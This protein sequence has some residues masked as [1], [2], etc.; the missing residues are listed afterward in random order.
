MKHM[1]ISVRDSLEIWIICILFMANIFIIGAQDGNKKVVLITGS[2]GGIGKATAELLIEEG[3][4]VYGGDILLEKNQY[5]TEIGGY[6]LKMDISR[7]DEVEAGVEQIIKEQGRIDVLF[8]NAGYS[9]HGPVECVD[10]MDA[11][12]QFD[13]NVFGHARCVKAVL[14]YMR[15]HGGGNIIINTSLGGKI[16]APGMSWYTA[17][18]YALEAFADGL[19]MEVRKF[20][21][22]VSVIEP[23]AVLTDIHKNALPTLEKVKQSPEAGNYDIDTYEKNFIKRSSRGI[24]PSG[25]ANS[26]LRI[27]KSEYPERRYMPTLDARLAYN[28]HSLFG[29]GMTD[30]LLL[31][32]F[33]GTHQPNPLKRKSLTISTDLC[34][35]FNDGYRI[36]LNYHTGRLSLGLSYLDVIKEIPSVETINFKQKR[37]GFGASIGAFISDEQRG[38]NLGLE[39]TYFTKV[40]VTELTTDEELEKDLYRT[41]F[42]LGYLWQPFKSSGFYIEPSVHA[43]YAFGDKDLNYT[44]GK[45]FEK[46]GFDVSWPLINI[47]WKINF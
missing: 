19:R 34:A 24:D 46:E 1:L 11:Q 44:S 9:L 5:L 16:S 2:A 25:I 29:Y 37:Q 40:S 43:G 45:I 17:S 32:M 21:I 31:K 4:I 22:A 20:N 7:D 12:K 14:P 13:V 39:F 30:D 3:Y 38:L 26:V 23:G 6:P 10:I 41:G 8:A 28:L 33:F 35:L 36:G 15:A 47:G 27:I 42:Q 18:K